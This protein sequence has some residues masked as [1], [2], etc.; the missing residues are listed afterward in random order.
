MIAKQ[1]HLDVLDAAALGMLLV[2]L[3][4]LSCSALEKL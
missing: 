4:V 2:D 3:F 1:G